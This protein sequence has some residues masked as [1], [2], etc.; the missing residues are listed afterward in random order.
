V[1]DQ[2]LTAHDLEF[3]NREISP[4]NYDSPSDVQQLDA[5]S[6]DNGRAQGFYD[7]G[8]DTSR[9]QTRFRAVSEGEGNPNGQRWHR[10]FNS[11]GRP[12]EFASQREQQQ[13]VGEQS[14]QQIRGKEISGGPPPN[15]NA[16][17]PNCWQ[18]NGLQDEL[19]KTTQPSLNRYQEWPLQVETRSATH[20]SGTASVEY[21]DRQP[22]DPASVQA[23]NRVEG[24]PHESSAG[25]PQA[26]IDIPGPSATPDNEASDWDMLGESQILPSDT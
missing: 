12:G 6:P 13:L 23:L 2:N 20:E 21:S 26:N 18:L 7:E 14:G 17:P 15:S 11:E 16:Q 19:V 25:F 3:L 9:T 8:L 1:W 24:D 10:S 5:E 22:I 4:A